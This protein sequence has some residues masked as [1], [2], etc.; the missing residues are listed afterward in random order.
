M[1]LLY[2]VPRK[3]S[4]GGCLAW[5]RVRFGCASDWPVH[6]YVTLRYI[7]GLSLFSGIKPL[8]LPII[9]AGERQSRKTLLCM[10]SECAHP[11]FCRSHF[12]RRC[13]HETSIFS[14]KQSNEV[15]NF[16]DHIITRFR[17]IAPLHMKGT[18]D[19]EGVCL[20]LESTH[21]LQ[22]LSANR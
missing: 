6:I 12:G 16:S 2:G 15:N 5:S 19:Y 1:I 11:V 8:P 13:Q 3:V 9:V 7:G 18:A 17:V 22:Q 4:L 20:M 10:R 14:N 21:S